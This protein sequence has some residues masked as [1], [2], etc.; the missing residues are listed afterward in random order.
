M[1]EAPHQADSIHGTALPPLH[2]AQLP[3]GEAGFFGVE[4]RRHFTPLS[5]NRSKS[6][7]NAST[8]ILLSMPEMTTLTYLNRMRMGAL[9][10]RERKAN[11]LRLWQVAEQLGR[12][13]T[14]VQ[15]IEKG[16]R[17]LRMAELLSFAQLYKVSPNDLL[18]EVE[19]LAA[20]HTP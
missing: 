12:S 2:G 1:L 17:D 7:K 6:E 14:W 5:K 3:A 20:Q 15:R 8:V 10:R 13:I 18:Q 11:H 4:A 9:L 16:D 19:A